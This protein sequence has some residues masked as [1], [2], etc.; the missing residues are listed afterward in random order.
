MPTIYRVDKKRF[1]THH[2]N[3]ISQGCAVYVLDN[4]SITTPKHHIDIHR[5]N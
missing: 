2:I 5:G 3:P 4:M 1:E